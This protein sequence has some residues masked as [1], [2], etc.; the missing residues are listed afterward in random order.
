MRCPRDQFSVFCCRAYSIYTLCTLFVLSLYASTAADYRISTQSILDNREYGDHPSS[1][2]TYFFIRTENEVGF[3]FDRN[4][5]L[6]SG[7]SFLQEFGAPTTADHLH[8]LL[9][10]QYSAENLGFVIGSFPRSSRL[11]LP[12]S[13]FR[14]SANYFRPFVHGALFSAAKGPASV[15]VWVDWTGRQTDTVRETFLFGVNSRLNYD[16]LF[17]DQSFLMYHRAA[18]GIPIPN[19]HVRDNGA[20]TAEA[21]IK[22]SSFYFLDSLRVSAGGVLTLDRYRASNSWNTPKGACVRGELWRGSFGVSGL[23]YSG[24][25][26]NIMWGDPFYSLPW[27]A[28]ADLKYQFMNRKDLRIE[29]FQSFHF[30]QSKVGYSQHFLLSA[31]LNG[32]LQNLFS[33]ESE[34]K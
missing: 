3:S 20:L 5:S 28:R 6:R 14:D 4:H 33:N 16:I 9:Y 2:L 17:L 26:Q 29:F 19:D 30:T 27:F 7:F 23:Y 25:E 24:D 12:S 13:M 11:Q 34:E 31:E 8:L 15:D 10:Y 21:G 18:P 32:R 22:Q 1:D